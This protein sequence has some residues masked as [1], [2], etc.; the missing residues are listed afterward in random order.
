ARALV[1]AVLG[2]HHREGARFGEVRLAPH[3]RDDAIVFVGFEAVPF[4]HLGINHARA[5]STPD[6]IDCTADSRI[7]RPSALPRDDSHARSGCGMRPTTFR[8]SLHSPAIAAIEPFGFALS[9]T[10]P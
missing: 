10:S 1:A 9:V 2:P 6:L 3:E 4:E 5:T 7:T 8:V